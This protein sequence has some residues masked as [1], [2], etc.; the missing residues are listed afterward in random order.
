MFSRWTGP[1]SSFLA[2]PVAVKAGGAGYSQ[3]VKLIG[4]ELGGQGG[5][6][7]VL[8]GGEGI[9]SLFRLFF[10]KQSEHGDILLPAVQAPVEPKPPA[11]RWV[12]SSSSAISICA[13]ITGTTISWAM[14]SPGWTVK[15]ASPEF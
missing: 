2:G 1:P 7:R 14:R 3:N 12:S 5:R 13:W 6:R 11:P 4:G 8:G 9:W 15:S 10:L